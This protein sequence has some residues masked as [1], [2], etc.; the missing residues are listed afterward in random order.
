M[1]HTGE[2]AAG[3]AGTERFDLWLALAAG[4]APWLDG[5][6]LGAAERL[7]LSAGVAS[8][9]AAALVVT[10]TAASSPEAA[11][12][13]SRVLLGPA[14]I[15][16]VAILVGVPLRMRRLRHG[17]AVG[18]LAPIVATRLLAGLGLLAIVVRTYASL[19]ALA[20][21]GFGVS[22]GAEALV[23]LRV[24][25][26]DLPPRDL[27]RR[28]LHS[29]VHL[30]VVSGL[31]GLALL[32]GSSEGRVLALQMAVAFYALAATAMAAFVAFRARL[33]EL[34]REQAGHV[35][36]A[37]SHAHRDH[38]HWLHDDVCSELRYL[39]LHVETEGIEPRALI[40]RLDQLDHRLRLR[41]LDEVLQT[42]SADLGEIIQP[43]VRT[44]QDNGVE[45]IEVPSF[46]TAG[47]VVSAVSGRLVQRAVAVLVANAIQAGTSTLRIRTEVREGSVIT[48]EVEDDAG[49]MPTDVVVGGRGLAGL[50]RDLG[51]DGLVLER[52]ATGTLAR[53]VVHVD[54]THETTAT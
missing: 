15:A 1:A 44:A 51:P 30:G 25:G 31:L 38:A 14:V 53:A 9:A 36:A 26:I 45:I 39:R 35:Q 37:R 54:S 10:A 6:R 52:T 5:E 11:G 32:A 7:V 3:E 16:L 23:T 19:P 27:L 17:D 48:I 13:G 22:G 18:R 21:A 34:D 49:G 50:R 24:L 40:G 43:Y 46:E 33:G 29:T 28:S 47:L 2:V 12:A 4:P 20:I 8:A 42:G 41:Q